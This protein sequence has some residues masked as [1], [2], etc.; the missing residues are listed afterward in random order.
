[1][2]VRMRNSANEGSMDVELKNQ[3]SYRNGRKCSP[4]PRMSVAKLAMIH[5]RSAGEVVEDETLTSQPRAVSR[6]EMSAS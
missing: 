6:V 4:I 5:G 3:I 1:M 2:K